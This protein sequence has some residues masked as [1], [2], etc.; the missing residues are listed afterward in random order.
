ME[1]L[2]PGFLDTLRSIVLDQYIEL[3]RSGNPVKAIMIFLKKEEDLADINDF[4]CEACPEL[5]SDP[6]TCPWV[7][8]FSGVGPATAK[9]IRERSGEISLYLTTSVM[10]MGINLQNIEVVIM[11][12]PFSQLHSLVQACGRGGRKM[13]EKGRK[14]VV[15]YLLWNKSDIADNVDISPAVRELCMTEKCLKEVLMDHF[16]TEG[17][18]GGDWCCSNC[19]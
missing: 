13:A 15:F 3:V 2:K 1:W 6:S 5:A 18:M 12:R 11:V 14:R 17:S 9:S 10:L 8:N 16:G 4:L 7:V 19:D